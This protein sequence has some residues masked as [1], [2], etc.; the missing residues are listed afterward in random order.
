MS[1]VRSQKIFSHKKMCR[2]N[3]H[4][5]F[6]YSNKNFRI[7]IDCTILQNDLDLLIPLETIKALKDGRKLHV[8]KEKFPLIF[9]F[10]PFI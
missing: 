8:T 6:I 1:E 5:V 2:E 10:F 3:F 7:T 4:Q 9:P